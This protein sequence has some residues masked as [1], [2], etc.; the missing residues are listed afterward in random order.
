MEDFN[1]KI[2]WAERLS[3]DYSLSGVGFKGYGRWYNA[4]MYKVRGHVFKSV[5]GGLK[6]RNVS[7]LDIGSG[8]GFYISLFQSIGIKHGCGLDITEVAVRNLQSRFPDYQFLQADISDVNSLGSLMSEKFDFI[9]AFDILFHIVDDDLFAKAIANISRLLREGGYFVFSDNFVHGRTARARHQV[10]RSLEE[11]SVILEANGFEILGRK[12]IFVLM[13]APVDSRCPAMS[14]SFYRAFM[15]PVRIFNPLGF[16]Y[17][18][19]L[20]PIELFLI[21]A[22]SESPTTE[23]MICK[24]REAGRV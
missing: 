24:K 9:T 21:N 2:Y 17:G 1:A 15:A 20:Y 6:L 4:W 7:A 22:L 5:V 10:S 14:M 8:T 23:I 12:P 3:K 19:F 18:M 13:N 11:I 16:L